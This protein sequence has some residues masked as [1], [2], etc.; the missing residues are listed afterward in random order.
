MESKIYLFEVRQIIKQ[1][2][3][4]KKREK[5]IAAM[6]DKG[7][8][9]YHSQRTANLGYLLAKE[10]QFSDEDIKFFVEACLEHDIG[11]TELP[12]KY[13]TRPSD[14]FSEKDFKVL[15]KHAIQGHMYL[16]REGRSPR[17]YN[18]VLL[19]HEFQQRAYPNMDARL[20]RL[21]RDMEDVDIDNARLLAML[22]V[23][24]TITFGRPYVRIEP[25]S[26]MRAEIILK[27]Q[28]NECGDEEVIAFLFEQF[29][30]IKKLWEDE[31]RR[32]HHAR[33]TI[34]VL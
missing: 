9:L 15:Q 4:L 25:L 28:F 33:N 14:K 32:R 16:K 2:C 23:F 18:P 29:A 10:R 5:D 34:V 26:P 30:S 12:M 19:H 8:T 27:K 6:P 7:D 1:D 20:L 13:P 3:F 11:K 17:V 31:V 21:L 24:D 22:D